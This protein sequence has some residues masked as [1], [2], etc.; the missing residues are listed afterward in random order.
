MGSRAA[1][2]RE[3]ARDD[4]SARA[5]L[6]HPQPLRAEAVEWVDHTL[7]RPGADSHTALR[8]RALCTK[9]RCLWQMGF[10]AE[11]SGI[12]AEAEAIAR[13]LDDPVILSQAL[14]LRVQH[15]VDEE[16]LQG[17]HARGDGGL[18]CASDLGGRGG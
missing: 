10:T 6:D 2:R 15:E 1:D 13:R 11:K 9:A 3:R 16:R 12:V 14:Q 5:L 18:H 7:S 8:V 17:A 4:R